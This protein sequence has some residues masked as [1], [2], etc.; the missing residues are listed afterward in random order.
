MQTEQAAE[1]TLRVRDGLC[2]GR[3]GNR[4]IWR[5]SEIC[6]NLGLVLA[7]FGKFRGSLLHQSFASRL[8]SAPEVTVSGSWEEVDIREGSESEHH[9]QALFYYA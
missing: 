1:L 9:L 8:E 3:R 7:H 2:H 6:L 5:N 4:G